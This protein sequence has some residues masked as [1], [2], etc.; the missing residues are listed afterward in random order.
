MLNHIL[1]PLD[2]SEFSEKAIEYGLNIVAPNGKITFVTVLDYPYTGA[3]YMPEMMPM[4][5]NHPDFRKQVAE[6]EASM[7]TE[8]KAYLEKYAET[9][10]TPERTVE[11]VVVCGEPAEQ[12]IKTIEEYHP[13]AVVMATHGRTGLSRWFLGSVTQRVLNASPIPIYVIPNRAV[14]E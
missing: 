9:L 7:E 14:K 10:R 11:T 4:A 3:G 8:A 12:V 13:D 5:L 1:I 6:Q 2:G